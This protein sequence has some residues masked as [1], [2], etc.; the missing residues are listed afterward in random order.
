MFARPGISQLRDQAIAD[1]LAALGF[2]TLL[3]RS[4]LR[5]LAYAQAGLAFGQYG[6]LDW[7]ARQAT[8]FTATGIFLEAWAAL[9]GVVR[10]AAT[11]ATASVGGFAGTGTIP[12]GSVLRRGDGF[13][14]ITLADLV[15]G[16]DSA[17][18]AIEA[19]ASGSA[20]TV[21]DGTVLVLASP[22]IGVSGFGVATHLAPGTDPELD[23]PFRTRM[24]LQW[25]SPP[26]GGSASDYVKWAL[27]V[28]GVSRAWD[29]PL[30]DGAGT[31]VVYAM[32]DLAEAAHAGFPQG[33]DGVAAGEARDTAAT[34]DQLVLANAIYPLRPA[35]ALIYSVSPIAYPVNFVIHPVTAVPST[36][37]PLVLAAIDAAFI[38][39][40]SPLA[41]ELD[42]SPF[43]TAIAA[44]SGM[45]KFTL[46]APLAP[47]TAP[48][49][50]LP[51]RGTVTYV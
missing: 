38:A 29:N 10:E 2:P 39:E 32:W 18:V 31:V 42:F 51:V 35:T 12:A 37:Q 27:A 40:A 26:Q 15:V 45:P 7:I 46:E 50:R 1:I 16:G 9:V 8:P 30:G 5:A 48:L 17:I 22:V 4:P 13:Q 23:A 21:D 20:Y 44:V 43:A 24:L 6:Y 41:T 33:T 47:L 36:V 49:G 3:R 34:G 11:V 14:Y 28:P 19:A 25:S